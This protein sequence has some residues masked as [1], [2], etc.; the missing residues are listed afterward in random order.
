MII[1]AKVRT[2]IVYLVWVYFFASKRTPVVFFQKLK[3]QCIILRNL[4]HLWVKFDLFIHQWLFGIRWEKVNSFARVAIKATTNSLQVLEII[5]LSEGRLLN[6]QL[7]FQLQLGSDLLFVN[8]HRFKVLPVLIVIFT[9][10]VLTISC[11]PFTFWWNAYG[12]L[13][14][15][16]RNYRDTVVPSFVKGVQNWIIAPLITNL[17]QNSLCRNWL[18]T[19]YYDSLVIVFK[20]CVHLRYV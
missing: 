2:L 3:Q 9:I 12:P 8:F 19:L 6:S 14:R 5:T 18:L 11:T 17:P 16:L 13:G 20:T 7:F 1:E 4:C 15:V 10:I